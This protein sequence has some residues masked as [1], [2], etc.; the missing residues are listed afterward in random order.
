MAK[1]QELNELRKD[2]LEE[3]KRIEADIHDIKVTLGPLVRAVA[4]MERE[5]QNLNTRLSRV[6]R[7]TGLAR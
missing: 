7:K 4:I 1:K 3:F 6:E 2:V 5:I